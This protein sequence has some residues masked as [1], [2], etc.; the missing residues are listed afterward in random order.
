MSRFL[1]L[2]ACQTGP[3]QRSASRLLAFFQLRSAS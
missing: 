3:I 1:T 2:A